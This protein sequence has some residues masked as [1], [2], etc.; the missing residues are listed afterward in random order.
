MISIFWECS[1]FEQEGSEYNCM[2]LSIVEDYK[3]LCQKAAMIVAGQVTY[4]PRSVLGLPTGSTP[5]CMYDQLAEMHQNNSLSFS[6]VTTF[7]LDEYINLSPE[8]PGSFHSYMR[9]NFFN[10][11]DIKREN[12]HIPR[13]QA[14]NIEQEC[15]RYEEKIAEAGGIDLQILGLGSN[16]HIAFN[17]PQEELPRRTSPV[18]LKEHTRKTNS[19]YFQNQEEVPERAITMGV[20][21]ILSAKRILLIVNGESKA[22]AVE[23]MVSGG[24]TTKLPASFLHLHD[25]VRVIMDQEAAKNI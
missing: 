17:E 23:E 6:E 5:M 15:R 9:K 10:K 7:N 20:G 14:E 4:K 22:K 1:I 12:T 8:H 11:V 25:D 21:T 2:D 24:I 19:S 16:G 3:Q 13:G 18:T